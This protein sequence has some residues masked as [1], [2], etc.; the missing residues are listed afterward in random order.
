M[1]L[2]KYKAVGHI[3]SW[4]ATIGEIPYPCVH[5]H[6][7]RWEGGRLI[8]VDPGYDPSQPKWAKFIE[9][10]TNEQRAILT[11]DKVLGLS[12]RGVNFKRDGYIAFYQIDNLT[13][14]QEALRFE[15]ISRLADLE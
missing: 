7:V 4:F 2:P 3:G 8:Y 9:A 11:S 13:I 5:N 10:L 14:D 15:F 1:S 6:W 12:G